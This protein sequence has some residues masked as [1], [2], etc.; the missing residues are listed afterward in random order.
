M[1]HAVGKSHSRLSSIPLTPAFSC[2]IQD[3]LVAFE[4]AIHANYSS[5]CLASVDLVLKYSFHVKDLLQK[6]L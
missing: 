2:L 1:E 3:S 6:K 5:A 4:V